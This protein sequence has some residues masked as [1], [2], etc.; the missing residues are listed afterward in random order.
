MLL[1]YFTSDV[2][3]TQLGIGVGAGITN[4]PDIKGNLMGRTGTSD[5]ADL[6]DQ[7]QFA[8]SSVRFYSLIT[9]TW[10]SASRKSG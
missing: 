10:F 9:L 2:F 8:H 1:L 7:Q 5:Y 3:N 6:E 4:A